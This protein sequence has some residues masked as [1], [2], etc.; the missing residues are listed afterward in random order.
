[1]NTAGYAIN[2]LSSVI[3]IDF[4]QHG[5]EKKYSGWRRLLF[6][7][8]GCV[9]YFLVVTGMNHLTDFE[10]LL[11]VL[12]GAI[13]IAYGVLALKGSFFDKIF[14]SLMWVL[15]VLYGSFLVH[16]AM[17]FF[18]GKG[19][20][21]LREIYPNIYIYA[22]V[23]AGAVKF[24]LGRIVLKFYEVREGAREKEDWLI[25][26]A[27]LLVL[28]NGLLM[29]RLEMEY[30]T[31]RGAQGRLTCLLILQFASVLFIERVHQK[32]VAYKKEKI[33]SAF[34]LQ[35]AQQAEKTREENL[36]DMYRV[37]REINHWR[38][39]M[40]GK[41]SVLYYLQKKGSY[42]E[43]EKELAKAC[44]EFERYPELPQATGNEGLDAALIKA[45]A[46]CREEEIRFSY[47]IMGKP[48]QIDRMAMGNLMWNLFQ[49]GIEACRALK[50]ERSMDVV[51]R[52][53]PQTTEIRLENS[54][55]GS[56]LEDNP[57]LQS[58]KEEPIAHG[59]GMETIYAVIEDYRGSYVCFEEDGR[60]I[61]EI[62]LRHSDDGL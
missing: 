37:S 2:V 1:M 26:G 24:I 54:L 28:L 52:V 29:F 55:A 22:S 8:M 16:G 41:L 61:Q 17:G 48:E 27:L 39:D 36:R 43:V 13:L 12:Y 44:K 47:V 58:R 32:L 20:L 14:L 60:F 33:E 19:I 23:S 11:S 56:V 46:Q 34:Q 38:H 6:F 31:G 30:V 40:N 35:M 42:S 9:T 10:G 5:F 49:N 50:T 18:T 62:I 7:V 4:M 53:G 59:F 45:A 3:A 15:V 51:L 25:A 57:H 21:E